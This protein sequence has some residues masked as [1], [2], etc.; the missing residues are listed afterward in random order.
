MCW[1]GDTYLPLGLIP[2]VLTSVGWFVGGSEYGRGPWPTCPPLYVFILN[3]YRTR[4]WL[5]Y[6]SETHAHLRVHIDV[7]PSPSLAKTEGKMGLEC[8]FCMGT[9]E[10][11][12]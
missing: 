7:P 2:S 6:R 11:V 12:I 5:C 1:L 10:N 3:V 4:A 9:M 8:R